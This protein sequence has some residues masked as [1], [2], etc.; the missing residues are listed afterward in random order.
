MILYYLSSLKGPRGLEVPNDW[1]KATVAPIP[2]KDKLGNYKNQG[3]LVR[4]SEDKCQ[5]LSP[6]GK[7]PCS[8][9][10]WEGRGWGAALQERGSDGQLCA[11]AARTATC[12]VCE[13]GCSGKGLFPFLST[14]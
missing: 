10:G 5:V 11:R 3:D 13:Q 1:R 14:C 6:G 4:F 12:L 2:K 9:L 8:S 7:H